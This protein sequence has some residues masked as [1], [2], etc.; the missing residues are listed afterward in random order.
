MAV[1]CVMACALWIYLLTD[2]KWGRCK[3]L[4]KVTLTITKHPIESCRTPAI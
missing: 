1:V 2:K 4:S 3:N